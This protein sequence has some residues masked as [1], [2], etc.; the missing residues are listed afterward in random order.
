MCKFDWDWKNACL[1]M[2]AAIVSALP[3]LQSEWESD[4][5]PAYLCRSNQTR[6]RDS[7]PAPR[8]GRR[9]AGD[10]RFGQIKN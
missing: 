7:Y 1:V 6:H 3:W 5:A 10:T 2:R 8:F 9:G 4:R